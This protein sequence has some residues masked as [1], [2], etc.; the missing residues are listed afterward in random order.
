MING[1]KIIMEHIYKLINYYFLGLL[2]QYY[3]FLY[4]EIY[5]DN[6][7]SEFFN[8]NLNFFI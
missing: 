4:T 6:L 2:L 3:M 1:I 7:L 8:T 5:V